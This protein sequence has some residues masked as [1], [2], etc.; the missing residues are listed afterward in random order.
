MIVRWST[1]RSDRFTPGIETR[2]A[3]Y[4]RARGPQGSYRLVQKILFPPGLDP[5]T[6]QPEA[7]PPTVYA[8]PS[9]NTIT[10]IILCLEAFVD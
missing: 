6:V 10:C 3:F 5:K 2:Y 9:Y 4:R 1:P 7:S 8:I